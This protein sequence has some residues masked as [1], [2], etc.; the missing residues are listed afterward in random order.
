M[1]D[2]KLFFKVGLGTFAIIGLC[3]LANFFIYYGVS[4]IFSK[5]ST[6]A[7]MIFN[8]VTAGFFYYMLKSSSFSGSEF[9]DSST[10]DINKAFEEG[11]SGGD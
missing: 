3:S 8:F 7:Q 10:A 6:V 11:L 1:I 5:I 4:N 2:T 9:S